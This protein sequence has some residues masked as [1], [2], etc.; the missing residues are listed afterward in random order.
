MTTSLSLRPLPS[1]GIGRFPPQ[2]PPEISIRSAGLRQEPE[3]GEFLCTINADRAGRARVLFR[4]SGF[5]FL[6]VDIVNL[7]INLSTPD[8]VFDGPL[9]RQSHRAFSGLSCGLRP[10]G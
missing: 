3:G 2:E 8:P 5:F 4:D 7:A 10:I 9:S 1:C 6:E